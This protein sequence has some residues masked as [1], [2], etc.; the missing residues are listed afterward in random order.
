MQEKFPALTGLRFVAAMMVLIS[1]L[2][3]LMVKVEQPIAFLHV[4]GSLA[5]AGMTLFFVL[6]GFVIHMNYGGTVSSPTGLWNFF[7]ARFARL[8]PLYIMFLCSD[9]LM[10]FGFHQLHEQRLFALPFYLTLTQTWTYLPIDGNALVYQFGWAPSV[11][12]SI[13]TEWFFYFAFPFLSLGIAC[14]Q[15]P[16]K[17]SIAILALCVFAFFALTVMNLHAGGIFTYGADRYG[18][19]G[20][21]GQDGLYRWIAYFSPY[22]RILEFA[23]GCLISALVRALAPHTDPQQEVGLRLLI[24]AIVGAAALQWLMF[25]RANTP[26]LVTALHMNFGFAPFAA[27]IIFC[28]ARYEN[29]IVRALSTT[30]IV[31][32]G[33]A[34]YSIYLSHMIIINAFRYET[35]IISDAQVVI[36]VCIQAATTTIA[37]IG[38]SLVLWSLVEMPARRVVR[39]WLTV[40]TVISKPA[41]LAVAAESVRTS[42]GH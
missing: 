18:P 9:L 31:L 17:L 2:L 34:S 20:A 35:P 8:Y 19:I 40:P 32:A 14:L 39:R 36:V 27:A 16:R 38:F 23:L 41:T 4:L 21:D 25:G 3:A 7:A 1:H 33:E 6:S 10:K 30:R 28:C 15:T 42:Y 5:G 29:A 11:A 12:W 37:I 22:V 13:S 26:G 24:G